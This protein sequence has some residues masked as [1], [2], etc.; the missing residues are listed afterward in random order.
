VLALGHFRDRDRL[1]TTMK[2]FQDFL[3]VADGEVE[4]LLRRRVAEAFPGD[5]F[6]G[7]EDGGAQA[8]RLW[9][10]DPI[11]GTANFARGEPH[12]GI[13]IGFLQ[14]GQ[15]QLGVVAVPVLEELFAGMHGEGAALNGRPIRVAGT[16]DFA[17]AAVEIGWSPRRPTVAY[18]ELIARIMGHG[19]MMKRGASGALG[20]CWTACGRTDA[21][22]E[23]HI[24]SWDVAAGLVIAME[25]GAVVN[26]FFAG[27]GL[28]EGNSVL[29]AT[30]ALAGALADAMGLDRNMLQLAH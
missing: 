28:T 16:T 17:L 27:E 18:I 15:P 29:A 25:A 6:L 14:G 13:S 21:Y 4:A 22:L 12:W 7:E 20:L 30:P 24:N 23:L 19:A 10:V 26:D 1:G 11:D 2:G 9:V 3:T 5:G 8:E